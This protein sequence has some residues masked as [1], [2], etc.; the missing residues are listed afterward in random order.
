MKILVTGATGRIGH[1]LVEE[2]LRRNYEVRALVMPADP[3]RA[4]IEKPGVEAIEGHL[5]D[6]ESLR[7]AVDDID[8][9][10]HLAA[11]LPQGRTSDEIFDAN[12]IGTY[13]LLEALVRHADRI[14]RFV[15]A[16]TDNV[17]WNSKGALYLPI[18]EEHPRINDDPYGMSKIM[19]EEMCWNYMR[20][21][22]LPVTMPRFGATLAC[23]E[24][25]NPNSIWAGKLFANRFLTNLLSKPNLTGE[26]QESVEILTSHDSAE[27]TL[28][29]AYDPQGDVATETVNDARNLAEGLPLLLEKEV[30]VGEVFHL[31][32]A[33]PF[34]YDELVKHISTVTGWPYIEV[35]VS[36]VTHWELSIAKAQAILGYNPTR[37]VFQMVDDG[38]EIMK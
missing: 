21:C 24:L 4:R 16:S 37:D 28:V 26:E 27:P 30:A 31:M 38:W 17:Y 14:Q 6:R 22:G 10:Y 5:S 1:L 7:P 32:A 35:T 11:L 13:N 12:V 15:M 36:S 23:H 9:I 34:A 29:I 20:R 2:L 18:D 33:H 19:C 25:V 8:A 3:N